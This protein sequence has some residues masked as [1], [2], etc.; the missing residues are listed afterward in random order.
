MTQVFQVVPGQ[1]GRFSYYIT[2]L[3][4][5]ELDNI[6]RT[7]SEMFGGSSELARV[8]SRS[9]QKRLTEYL[10]G[11]PS[12]F[13]GPVTLVPFGYDDEPA[14]GEFEPGPP[15]AG[16]LR[17]PEPVRMLAADGANRL[18]AARAAMAA[19]PT[20]AKDAVPVVIV[21]CR[22]PEE[23]LGLAR[24]LSRQTAPVRPG[25]RGGTS[26]VAGEGS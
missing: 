10:L 2:S 3:S 24:D 22:S 12:R 13:S 6:A 17:F 7:A 4:W 20:L 23:A 14:L 11:S 16:L 15:G 21:P 19:Q 9:G 26:A 18:A 25:G 5:G 1:Q 8:E